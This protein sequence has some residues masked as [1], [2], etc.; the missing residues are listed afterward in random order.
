ML[1]LQRLFD[2]VVSLGPTVIK[3]LST[4][5]PLRSER[6]GA[7]V[8]CGLRCRDYGHQ[9]TKSVPMDIPALCE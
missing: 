7:L 8:G 1:S 2:K 9:L 6:V 4:L 3:V 5:P